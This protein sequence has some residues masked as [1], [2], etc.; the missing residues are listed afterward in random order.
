MKCERFSLSFQIAVQDLVWSIPNK[1]CSLS[2]RGCLRLASSFGRHVCHATVPPNCRCSTLEGTRL[3]SPCCWHGRGLVRGSLS[4]SAHH[5]ALLLLHLSAMGI[6][7]F[8]LLPP[9]PMPS[10]LIFHSISQMV[11]K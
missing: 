3:L 10:F 9:F 8:Y 6:N 5:T 1:L 4:A 7:Q 11:K 2:P